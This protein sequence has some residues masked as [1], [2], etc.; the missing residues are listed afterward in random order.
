MSLM[1]KS[2]LLLL[3]TTTIMSASS[4]SPPPPQQQQL[5]L[6]NPLTR[7]PT[8]LPTKSIPITNN[9]ISNFTLHDS[10]L[11]R[12]HLYTT[13]TF[14]IHGIQT[15]LDYSICGAADNHPFTPP[16]PPQQAQCT[17]GS[18]SD[19]ACLCLFWEIKVVLLVVCGVLIQHL[20]FV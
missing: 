19:A 12:P 7:L 13:S 20:L 10:L 17:N 5:C 9:S 6:L 4:P 11:S 2:L 8:L 3:F 16:P 15:F 14:V 1:A 18:E